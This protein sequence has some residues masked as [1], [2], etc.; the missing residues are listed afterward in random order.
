VLVVLTSSPARATPLFETNGDTLGM[1]GLQART[2]PGGPS[3]AYFNPALLTD[4]PASMTDG[5]SLLH[6]QINIALDGRLG[7]QFDV[8]NNIQSAVHSGDS[9]APFDL[10]PLPTNAI[11][12]GVPATDTMAALPARPRQHAGSGQ[13]TLY[14][15]SV[16]LVVKLFRDYLTFGLHTLLPLKDFME[17]RLFYPDEREQYFSNSLHPELYSDRLTAPSVALGLG[18]RIF[19]GL[20]IGVGGSLVVGATTRASVYVVNPSDLTNLQLD[21][22]GAASAG[23]APH[24]GASYTAI[25]KRLRVSA[26]AHAPSQARMDNSFGFLL[27]TGIAQES[28]FDFLLFYRPWMASLGASFDFLPEEKKELSVAATAVYARWRTY[29]DRHDEKPI[30]SYGW[31]DTISPT[32]GL[33]YGLDRFRS[34]LDVGYTPT[35]IPKQT[36]RSNYVD[37]D[38]VSASMGA[39]YGFD[40]WETGLTVGLVLQMQGLI[41]R[42]QAKLSTP[43]DA[44]GKNLAPDRVKD[45]VPDDAVISGDPVPGREGLQT[46]NP[47]WPGFGSS[48]WLGGGSLYVGVAF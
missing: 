31:A 16:G 39:E 2:V 47:G 21:L 40:L 11:E 4:T 42:Y 27:P 13:Q 38:K 48:G 24:F 29:I 46:N 22:N 43:T 17:L 25:E 32:I 12:Y 30:D 44:S 9:F 19:D 33:R 5:F 41:E 26:V 28:G 20:S 18:L 10:Y 34:Y 7:T 37:N 23:F 8:P 6:Q 35:P 45:E 3:A 1:G 36:G 14:Y 15:F